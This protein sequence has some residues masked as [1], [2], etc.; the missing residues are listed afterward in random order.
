MYAYNKHIFITHTQRHTRIQSFRRPKCV[1]KIYLAPG[2]QLLKPLGFLSD[3]G[4]VGTFCHNMWSLVFGSW[5]HFRAIEVKWV[6]CYSRWRSDFWKA[7][8]GVG[9][10]APEEPPEKRCLGLSVRCFW[11]LGSGE[12]TEAESQRPLPLTPTEQSQ[13]TAQEEGLRAGRMGKPELVWCAGRGCRRTDLPC[14]GSGLMCVS[15]GCGRTSFDTRLQTT[16]VWWVDGQPE[17]RSRGN[18]I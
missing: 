13:R 11:L 10:P 3:Q 5:G 4:N 1:F 6:S 2:L 14:A 15:D 17:F 12:G 8:E 9:G 16:V 7:P 18:W